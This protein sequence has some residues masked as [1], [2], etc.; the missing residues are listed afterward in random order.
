M[1]KYSGPHKYSGKIKKNQ[2]INATFWQPFLL[3]L[4]DDFLRSH[5][6]SNESRISMDHMFFGLPLS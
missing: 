5:V 1:E 2:V 4:E 3:V 6:N